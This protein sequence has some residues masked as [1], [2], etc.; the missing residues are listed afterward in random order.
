MYHDFEEYTKEVD[1]QKYEVLKC[2]L[3]GTTTYR[4]RS[5]DMTNL[6]CYRKVL[7][8]QELIEKLK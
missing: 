3:C 7:K 2:R 8:D 1:G 6:F 4:G 5:N